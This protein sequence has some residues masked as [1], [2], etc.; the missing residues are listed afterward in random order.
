[1]INSEEAHPKNQTCSAEGHQ[2]NTT[3]KR[4]RLRHREGRRRERELNLKNL[5]RRK[6]TSSLDWWSK[7]LERKN[8]PN[9]LSE[10][11]TR[12]S[13]QPTPR[14]GSSV[15]LKQVKIQD[16]FTHSRIYLKG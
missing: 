3:I 2:V 8:K 15:G 12:P 6:E 5:Q 1:M 13:E 11:V 10:T 7:F 4:Q 14:T 9:K 16:N